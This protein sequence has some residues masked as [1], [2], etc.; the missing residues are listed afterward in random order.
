MR[1]N[2]G[3]GLLR[4]NQSMHRM[5]NQYRDY[6]LIILQ[7]GL[8][9]VGENDSTNYEGYARRMV[10]VIERLQ[11]AF[12]ESSILLVSIS[13]RSSNQEGTFKTIPAIPMMRDAQRHMALKTGI[14]FWDLYEA[15]GGENS[16]VQYATATP[17]LAAKDYTHLT[18]RGGRIIAMK[19]AK[20]LLHDQKRYENNRKPR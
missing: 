7:Y 19:L 10:T 2:S 8:N 5:F 12:P 17:T 15:M 20:A 4:I 16:M 11:T 6:K 18:F 13:D 14:A 3:M 9:V 1:G